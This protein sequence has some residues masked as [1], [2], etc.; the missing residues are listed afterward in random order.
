MTSP[1]DLPVF[2]DEPAIAEFSAI[3]TTVTVIA[4]EP[5]HL[6]EATALVRAYLDDLDRALSR[7]REDSEV[8]TLAILARDGNAWTYAS[9]IF[10]DHLRA[11][12]R[13][14][15]LSD[16]LVDITVGS[17]LVA[18]GYDADL[19]VVQGRSAYE[20]V[21]VPTRPRNV[22]LDE[23]SGCIETTGGTLLDFGATA[24]AHAADVL[25]AMLAERL[26]GGFLV[27]LGGDIATAGAAPLGGWRVGVEAADGSIP[28]VMSLDGVAVATSS[29]CRRRWITSDGERHHIIDPRTGR[30]AE[31]RWAQISCA[32]PTALA[33]NAASTAAVILDGDAAAWLTA[34]GIA[35][36]LERR[37]GS[38]VTTPGWP[39]VA[40]IEG[41][42]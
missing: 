40:L 42:A 22:W 33:A 39:R 10:V 38:V 29:T 20:V 16:G 15:Q 36:R 41:A 5:A 25:A 4:A 21:P 35:A 17:H 23:S 37:D 18:Q 27:D 8:S 26:G 34:R 13:A 30:A 14:Y 28:Q 2:L 6:D 32:A 3:G 24:K 1:T 19:A 31:T 7:F 12:L 11:A 9:D